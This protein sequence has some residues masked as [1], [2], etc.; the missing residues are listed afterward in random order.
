MKRF[1]TG[2]LIFLLVAAV[3][4]Y[5]LYP[6]VS[7]Q[8]CQRRD[9]KILTAYR[10]KTAALDNGQ[11][12]DLFR[13]ARDWNSTLERVEAGDVFTAGTPRTTRE[14][15]NRLNVHSGVIGELVIPCIRVSLP[16]YHLSSET[17]ATRK[18]VHINT[19]SLPADSAGEHIVLAGP[20]KLKP[21]GFPGK[22]G[23]TD[24]RMLEDLDSGIPGDLVIL[25]VLD[26][27]MVYR[28]NGVQMLSSAGLKELDLT[29]GAEEE[30]LTVISPRQDRRLLVR[31]ERIPVGEARALLAEED[32]VT[33]PDNWQNVLFLGCPVML[34]GLFVLWLTE[35]IRG[36]SCRIPGEG[37]HT[38]QIEQQVMEL[39]EH[40][41]DRKEPG[42]KR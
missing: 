23:L 1:V 22:I 7:D 5:F 2:I 35:R 3:L 17:P 15:Q 33:F 30:S 42:E 29:P 27:T 26:R 11:K 16:V 14:Y 21:E 32:R 19:S 20:G 39:L 4:G 24:S 9:A 31:A 34:A 8:L 37:R 28:V 10:E 25:N 6:V 38:E 36:R 18:L 13:E 12:A 40:T 41:A